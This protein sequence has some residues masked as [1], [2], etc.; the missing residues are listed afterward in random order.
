MAMRRLSRV[1]QP[2]L[3]LT[4]THAHVLVIV[5]VSATYVVVLSS[6]DQLF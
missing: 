3:F 5:L 2:H 1:Q 4:T 6:C